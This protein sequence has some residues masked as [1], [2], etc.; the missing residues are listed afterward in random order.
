MKHIAYPLARILAEKADLEGYGG[1]GV[2][3]TYTMLD[4]QILRGTGWYGKEATEDLAM[5]LCE[6]SE[7][8]NEA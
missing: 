3:A 5:K 1:D 8:H 4:G 6:W 2:T 7:S